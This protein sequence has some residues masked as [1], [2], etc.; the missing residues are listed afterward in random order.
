MWGEKVG[1]KS[2]CDGGSRPKQMEEDWG[3]GSGGEKGE[4]SRAGRPTRTPGR[5]WYL[6]EAAAPDTVLPAPVSTLGVQA[7]GAV[8]QEVTGC[9]AGQRGR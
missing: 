4:R 8:G 3:R 7:G 2:K 1:R 5:V 6:L 9:G